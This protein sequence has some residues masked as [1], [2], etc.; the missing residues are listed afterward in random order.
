IQKYSDQEYVDSTALIG[1]RGKLFVMQS[2]FQM[3]EHADSYDAVGCGEPYA[4]GAL[5][6]L[7]AENGIE[8]NPYDALML[9][10]RTSERYSSGVRAPHYVFRMRASEPAEE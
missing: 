10:L 8:A 2:N 7:D 3:L 5:F 9:A 4:L 1:Y 6:A